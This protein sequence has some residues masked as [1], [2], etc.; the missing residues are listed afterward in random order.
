MRTLTLDDGQTIELSDDDYRII[1]KTAKG[2]S[3]LTISYRDIA[4]RMF[5]GK[6]GY[7]VGDNAEINRRSAFNERG[8]HIPLNAKDFE[9]LDAYGGHEHLEQRGDIPQRRLGVQ[10]GTVLQRCRGRDTRDET[11][12]EVYPDPRHDVRGT[13]F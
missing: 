2:L 4:Q 10:G 11:P 7:W 13:R 12:G 8:V 3:S 6:P 5:L 9:Q 1:A